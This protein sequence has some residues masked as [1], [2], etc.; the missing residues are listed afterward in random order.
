MR[1]IARIYIT[2]HTGRYVKKCDELSFAGPFNFVDINLSDMPIRIAIPDLE[3][4]V[5]ITEL[6]VCIRHARS[7]LLAQE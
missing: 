1:G 5:E 4:V 6:G 7:E 3:M 2:P